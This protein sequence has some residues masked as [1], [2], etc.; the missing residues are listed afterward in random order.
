LDLVRLTS[1]IVQWGRTLSGR[2]SLENMNFFQNP[3]ISS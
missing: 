3:L 1:N 2:R